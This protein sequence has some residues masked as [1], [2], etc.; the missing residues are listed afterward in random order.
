MIKHYEKFRLE[1]ENKNNEF[2]A[3]VNWDVKDK[4][5]NDS[6]LIRFTFPD[7]TTSVVR[8]DIL[9]SIM[10]AIGTPE[11]Q[12]NMIPQ[13]ISKVRW[14]ETVLNVQ[15][16]KDIRKGESVVFPVKLSLPPI[17]EEILGDLRQHLN[18]GKKI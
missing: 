10:F 15:A 2:F 14:Y 7:G 13:T 6:K 4:K 12:Q 3:E 1:D 16:K 5:T 9:N 18:S 17:E 11:Q 8:R